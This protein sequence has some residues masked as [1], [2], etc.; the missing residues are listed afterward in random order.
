MYQNELCTPYI[1]CDIMDHSTSR[2]DM[3]DYDVLPPIS[4]WHCKP[5]LLL[6]Y[7]IYANY[8]YGPYTIFHWLATTIPLSI[9]VSY[10]RTNQANFCQPFVT[11]HFLLALRIACNIS[12]KLWIRRDIFF[13]ELVV[14]RGLLSWSKNVMQMFFFTLE[15][16]SLRMDLLRT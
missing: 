13:C 10:D 12:C 8:Y 4:W 5:F 11:C 16:I 3:L 15:S 14:F 2:C 6:P 7:T 1:I 9:S